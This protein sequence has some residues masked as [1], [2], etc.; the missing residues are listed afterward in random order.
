METVTISRKE[1]EE[2]KKK[3]Y[4]TELEKNKKPASH[5][6]KRLRKR[7]LEFEENAR[8]GKVYTREELSKENKIMPELKR[9]LR[10]VE[11]GRFA[12][13]KFNKKH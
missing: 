8:K 5:L 7:A 1:Y 9:A 2:L 12:E 3:A 4:L 13:I 11:E 10:D 6:V